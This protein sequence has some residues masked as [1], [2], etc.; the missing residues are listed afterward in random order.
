MLE[1]DCDA[2]TLSF[3]DHLNAVNDKIKFPNSEAESIDQQTHH[4]Y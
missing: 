3:I 2:L 1:R 4:I